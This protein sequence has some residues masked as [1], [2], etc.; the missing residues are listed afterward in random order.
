VGAAVVTIVAI[1]IVLGAAVG[2]TAVDVDGA[3]HARMN[4][5]LVSAVMNTEMYSID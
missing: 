4:I 5:P 3:A 2:D 1:G